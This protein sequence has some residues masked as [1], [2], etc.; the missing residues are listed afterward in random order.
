MLI[1]FCIQDNFHDIFSSLEQE[2][3]YL[4]DT[5]LYA[6]GSSWSLNIVMERHASGKSDPD[7]NQENI[8]LLFH[9]LRV[10]GIHIDEKGTILD[11][12]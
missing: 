12:Q 7:K 6:A 2:M 4:S 10:L 9:V 1:D 5:F 11:Q 3:C 8:N